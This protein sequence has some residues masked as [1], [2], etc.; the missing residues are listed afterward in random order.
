MIGDREIEPPEEISNVYN[1]YFSEG[2]GVQGKPTYNASL[3]LAIEE[4]KQGVTLESL[5]ELH[6]KNKK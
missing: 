2:G 5:W 6:P 4:P 1:A 3:G